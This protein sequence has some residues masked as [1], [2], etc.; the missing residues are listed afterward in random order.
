[1]GEGGGVLS[2]G[3]ANRPRLGGLGRNRGSHKLADRKT[4]V[5]LLVGA[6]KKAVGRYN[7]ES[8]HIFF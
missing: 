5:G 7:E 1:M 4:V 8:T 3:Y 6:L 2:A